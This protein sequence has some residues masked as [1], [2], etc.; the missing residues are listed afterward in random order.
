MLDKNFIVSRAERYEKVIKQFCGLNSDGLGGPDMVPRM[1]LGDRRRLKHPHTS[2][3]D[4]VLYTTYL[5]LKVFP[6]VNVF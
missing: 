5:H 2:H 3:Y 4:T 1:M 6:I